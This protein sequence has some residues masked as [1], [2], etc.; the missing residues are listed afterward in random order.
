[1]T[2]VIGFD[3][4]EK[5][6]T[7]ID[8]LS[9]KIILQGVDKTHTYVVPRVSEKTYEMMATTVGLVEGKYNRFVIGTLQNAETI[10]KECVVTFRANPETSLKVQSFYETVV[11]NIEQYLRDPKSFSHSEYEIAGRQLKRIPINQLIKLRDRYK[12]I[13][14]LEQDGI[15]TSKTPKLV[16]FVF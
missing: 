3:Y 6:T 10:L 15:E 2:H 5:H 9:L 1:L 13:I 12:R 4:E 7:D 14:E 8:Y 11:A 16:R